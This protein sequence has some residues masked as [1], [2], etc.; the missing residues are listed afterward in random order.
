MP[1]SAAQT[2][3][4]SPCFHRE[5]GERIFTPA[6]QEPHATTTTPGFSSIRTLRLYAW[7][8]GFPSPALTTNAA[9]RSLIGQTR[10]SRKKKTLCFCF[11]LGQGQA[12]Q[13]DLRT[14]FNRKGGT[15]GIPTTTTNKATKHRSIVSFL[16]EK[17]RVVLIQVAV[18]DQQR[19]KLFFFFR[20]R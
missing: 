5:E 3:F 14:Q 19:N 20:G 8:L 18:A 11:V 15:H 16:K 17:I 7:G 10:A 6:G 12:C 4:Q 2:L 13:V 1:I 9:F